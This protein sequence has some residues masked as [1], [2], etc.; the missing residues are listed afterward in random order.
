MKTL[1]VLLL[2]MLAPVSF[3]QTQSVR[4]LSPSD[5]PISVKGTVSFSGAQGGRVPA[6]IVAHNRSSKEVLALV[7]TVD[8]T[9]PNG[10]P[11]P[12]VLEHEYFFREDHVTGAGA[13][14]EIAS[15]HFDVPVVVSEY[16]RTPDGKKFPGLKYP[17]PHPP[18]VKLVFVQFE[19]GSSWGD[20]KAGQ[21]MIAER[22]TVMA[23]LKK[24][25]SASDESGDVGVTSVLKWEPSE[26]T[27]PSLR[28]IR[29]VLQQTKDQAGTQ[30]LVDLVRQKIIAAE[31][32]QAKLMS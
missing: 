10:E 27:S 8:M 24:L 32:R 19:D 12:Y 11:I 4:D 2:A 6:S 29:H 9:R 28:A 30:F 17:P 3:S 7:A 25:L 23:Y 16:V 22:P 1:T 21:A 18:E 15:G 20:E 26:K 14:F 31:A 13:D 5:C